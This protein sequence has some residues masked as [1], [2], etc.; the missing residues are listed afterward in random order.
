MK[1]KNY[2]NSHV[3][4]ET[5]LVNGRPYDNIIITIDNIVFPVKLLK[6]NS[7]FMYK[8]K[9]TLEEQCNANK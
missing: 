7:K 3:E 5:R 2:L 1:D 8:L 9:K 6:F 4:V